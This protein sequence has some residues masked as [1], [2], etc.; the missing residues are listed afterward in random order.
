VVGYPYIKYNATQQQNGGYKME[1]MFELTV[2]LDCDWPKIMGN[3]C[4]APILPIKLAEKT[5]MGYRYE[6]LFDSTYDDFLRFLENIEVDN[7]THLATE[8][9]ATMF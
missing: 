4:G 9:F 8:T 7:D 3:W 5:D 1:T 2:E 6:F